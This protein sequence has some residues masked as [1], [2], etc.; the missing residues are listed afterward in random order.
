MKPVWHS[1]FLNS[2]WYDTL[3]GL[4]AVPIAS[5]HSKSSQR[6]G[7]GGWEHVGGALIFPVATTTVEWAFC[8]MKL[9]KS[10]LRN[11]MGDQWLNDCLIIYIEK[12]VFDS[13]SNDAI[14]QY[15]QDMKIRREQL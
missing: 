14:V 11:K 3:W 10:D 2:A 1:S 4:F 7:K 5:Q 12:D 8:A 15:Y 6:A 13:V 9:I